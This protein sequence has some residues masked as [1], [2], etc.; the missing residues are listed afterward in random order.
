MS[1]VYN[2]ISNLQAESSSSSQFSSVSLVQ[3]RRILN[4]FDTESCCGLIQSRP[5]RSH[6]RRATIQFIDFC[7]KLCIH[8]L[9]SS[10]I[11]CC[12]IVV[13]MSDCGSD[14][15]G[16]NPGSSITSLYFCVFTAAFT[17]LCAQNHLL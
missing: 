12:S 14:D 5:Q 4:E 8:T 6:D 10:E 9:L 17:A 13:S 16:S 3:S 11:S 2:C 1:P 7:H 15:P